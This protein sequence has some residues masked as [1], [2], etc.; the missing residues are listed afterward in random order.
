MNINRYNYEEFFLMLVDN[1]L[2]ATEKKAVELFIDENPDLGLELSLLREAILLP[3]TTITLD[4]NFLYRNIETA[5]NANNYTEKFVLYVD[6]ELSDI[7]KKEVETFVLQHP[8]NQVDFT[9]LK[10]TKLKIFRKN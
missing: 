3:E 8:E 10:Q 1:E 2:S 7:E 4:K 9:L 5:I 6:N